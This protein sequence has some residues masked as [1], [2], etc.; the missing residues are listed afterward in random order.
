[1]LIARAIAVGG[2]VALLGLLVWSLVHSDN[3]ARFVKDV[4]K[5]ARPPAP[6]FALSVLW[7][8]EET[9]PESLRPRLADG[10]L[11][12]RELRGHPAVIN[13]WASWCVPCKGEAPAFAATA[14]RFAG[15]IVFVGIDVQDL[16]SSAKR[17][18]K[19]YK[20]NYVSVRDGTDATY[21]AYGLTGVPETYYVDSRGRVVEHAIGAV[22]QDELVA[23]I[24]ALLKAS[25]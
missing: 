5:G 10:R 4:S 9:W 11:G 25:S 8:H 23:S 14:K 21:T 18:L 20:V 24:N 3:G 13:F 19:R 7:N 22:S 2:V 6:Q 15:R 12:L 17:F 1:M 16:P